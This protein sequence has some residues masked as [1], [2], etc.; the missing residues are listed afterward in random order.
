MP[1]FTA[2]LTLHGKT[3]TG[4]SVPEHVITELNSG[5]RPPVH[6]T[7][8][9]TYSYRSTL[10]VMGGQTLLPVSAEHRAAA[11]LNA[12]DT[13]TVTLTPDAAPRE[14]TLPTDLQSALDAQPGARDA[15]SRL[16]PSR[17]R[18]HARQV[19]TA[20]ADATRTRRIQAVLAS[21]THT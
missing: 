18:E 19:E 8:N 4:L 13:V 11:G 10:G 21:L 16:S 12:G 3:A 6:V 2:T 15:F 20:R 7:L 5:R 1:T 17:Q 9:G 14:V